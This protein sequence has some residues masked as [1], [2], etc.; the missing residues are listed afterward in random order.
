MTAACTAPHPRGPDTGRSRHTSA[1]LG[2][3][4]R[5]DTATPLFHNL[6]TITMLS[7]EEKFDE[8]YHIPFHPSSP[9]SERPRHTCVYCPN[10]D[11]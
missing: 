10:T 9:G 2:Y 3:T 1:L 7:L 6:Q 4:T 5:P 8:Y 11:H